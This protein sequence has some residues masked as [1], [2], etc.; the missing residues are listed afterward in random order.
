VDICSDYNEADSL[1]LGKPELP[2]KVHEKRPSGNPGHS[3]IMSVP[4]NVQSQLI[5]ALLIELLAI[6]NQSE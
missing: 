2:H 4:I 6:I 1:K 3:F 5:K